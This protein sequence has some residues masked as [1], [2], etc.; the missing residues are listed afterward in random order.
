MIT[1]LKKEPTETVDDNR[2]SRLPM[3]QRLIVHFAI[4]PWDTCIGPLLRFCFPKC[5]A[6]CELSNSFS[7]CR[8]IPC[9]MPIRANT[10]GLASDPAG[11]RLGGDGWSCRSIALAPSAPL[12]VGTGLI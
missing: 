6:L 8:L 3:P 7:R 2:P 11:Q 1:L 12:S 9:I 4:N 10:I 5:A